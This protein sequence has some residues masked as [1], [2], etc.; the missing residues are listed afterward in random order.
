MGQMESV[1]NGANG[2]CSEWGKWRGKV[3]WANGE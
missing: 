1:V 2:E 3:N